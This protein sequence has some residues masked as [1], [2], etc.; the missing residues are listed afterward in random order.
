MALALSLLLPPSLSLFSFSLLTSPLSSSSPPGSTRAA[1]PARGR[2]EGV[3]ARAMRCVVVVIDVA[4]EVERE[5]LERTR[6]GLPGRSML[7]DML[8]R[9]L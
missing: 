7:L 8:L 3:L 4:V 9:S 6:G 1:S 5:G 2:A